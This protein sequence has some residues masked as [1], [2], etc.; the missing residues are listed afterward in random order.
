MTVEDLPSKGPLYEG[1][2]VLIKSYIALSDKW[3]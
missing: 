2:G 1:G 3:K